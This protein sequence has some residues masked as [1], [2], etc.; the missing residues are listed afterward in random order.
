MLC[1]AAG[2][3][4]AA[5]RLKPVL[6]WTECQAFNILLG[7]LGRCTPI[8]HCTIAPPSPRHR[9]TI[10]SPS[11]HH[12]FTIGSPSLPHRALRRIRDRTQP[13]LPLCRGEQPPRRALVLDNGGEGR[14]ERKRDVHLCGWIFAASAADAMS[15]QPVEWVAKL[16]ADDV[17]V[18]PPLEETGP[19]KSPQGSQ[20][21]RGHKSAAVTS[22]QGSQVRSVHRSAGGMSP[23]G[24]PDGDHHGD[25]HGDRRA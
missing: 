20:V 16:V 6:A 15:G 10:A 1:A 24:D 22:P 13:L 7:A 8:S 5:L 17:A 9:F 19:A 25:H 11:L 23:Q 4:Q 21:R 3:Q 14:R 12:R 2:Y 18:F